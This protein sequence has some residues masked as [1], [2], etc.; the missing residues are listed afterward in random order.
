ML[1]EKLEYKQYM[2]YPEKRLT[3][4]YTTKK[5]K[6]KFVGIKRPLSIIARGLLEAKGYWDK[7]DKKTREEKKII[8]EEVLS[9]LGKSCSKIMEKTILC[10]MPN[11]KKDIDNWQKKWNEDIYSPIETANPQKESRSTVLKWTNFKR[12]L[13]E[14]ILQGPLKER[15]LVCNIS[16]LEDIMLNEKFSYFSQSK[17]DK[18]E[19]TDGLVILFRKNSENSKNSKNSKSSKSSK[20][21]Q[22]N[23]DSDKNINFCNRLFKLVIASL[24]KEGNNE[25]TKDDII[26]WM[27]A[28]SKSH[29]PPKF[30]YKADA[31]NICL[32]E[33]S[34][35]LSAEFREKYGFEL[36]DVK[37]E[38]DKKNWHYLTDK[39]ALDQ[40]KEKSKVYIYEDIDNDG[41]L[42]FKYILFESP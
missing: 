17:K 13:C 30:Y 37:Q 5:D 38:M 25:I 34:F 23:E 36:R 7:E 9:E 31:T 2:D 6:I 27:G 12:I 1:N 35:I 15:Y 14:A 24:L 21:S 29:F 16:L 20:N 28:K 32:E 19:E 11:S 26:N 10:K 40:K 41:T 8:R 42:N 3:R 18:R 33:S 39:E 22:N 4:I